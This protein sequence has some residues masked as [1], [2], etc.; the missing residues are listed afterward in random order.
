MAEKQMAENV[1]SASQEHEQRERFGTR[2]PPLEAPQITPTEVVMPGGGA[3]KTP[4]A[5][6]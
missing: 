6:G 3:A 2:Q 1:V 4:Q 5:E